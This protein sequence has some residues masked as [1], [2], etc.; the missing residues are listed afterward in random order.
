MKIVCIS[1]PHGKW[2]KLQIPECD[3]LISTGDYSF[4]GEKHMVR[5]YHAWLNKQEAGYIISVQGNH[6]TFTDRIRRGV[7]GGIT[8][9][10]AK[11]IAE[12]ECPGVH[13]VEHELVEI[14]GVKIFCSAWTPF[15]CNWAYNA[16]R[17]EEIKKLW[18]D[19]PEDTQILATHGPPYK[20]LDECP[21]GTLVGCA[22]LWNKILQLKQLKMHC[23]GHIHHSSGEKDFN[24]IKFI[25]A[26]ICD[27]SYM[28]T[29][30][31][32]I[33]EL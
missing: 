17:G 6:E 28:P 13:F 25:N 9:A 29:N 18:D 20:I 8:F 23:F 27:E 33:F 16:H 24:G 19:I 30:P 31:I 12:K 2:G 3:I 4:R 32:R 22:D 14:E 15:F 1:D 7:N 11:E 10:Q 5:D 21:D 26:A